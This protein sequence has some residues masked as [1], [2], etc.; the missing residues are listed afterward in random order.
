[1]QIVVLALWTR[2]EI[3]DGMLSQ[4]KSADGHRPK[5]FPKKAGQVGPHNKASNPPQHVALLKRNITAFG[6]DPS[7]ILVKFVKGLGEHS[8]RNQ[9]RPNGLSI[10]HISQCGSL[11]IIVQTD[12]SGLQKENLTGL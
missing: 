2:L 8:M 11:G 10:L 3:S 1:M 9:P 5:P 12:L 6:V 7:T 4:N